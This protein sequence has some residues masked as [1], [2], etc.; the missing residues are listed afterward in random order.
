[1]RMKLMIALP[2]LM[3]GVQAHAQTSTGTTNPPSDWCTTHPDKCGAVSQD[4]QD[5]CKNNPTGCAQVKQDM[6]T[7]CTNHP[8]QC[9]NT[10]SRLQQ[11]Q[12]AVQSFDAAHPNAAT[13]QSN[14]GGRMANREERR[15]DRR[16]K[17]RQNNGTTTP[18][19]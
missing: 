15:T 4:M 6:Q 2:L 12:A 7:A 10:K 5:R 11:N 16:Q 14:V 8:E 17:F 19:Q 9:A 18:Q 13:Q 1:M 3:L